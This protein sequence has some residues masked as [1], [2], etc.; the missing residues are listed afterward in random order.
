LFCSEVVQES[1]ER[2]MPSISARV[3]QSECE[4]K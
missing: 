3:A 4:H 1:R 2:M